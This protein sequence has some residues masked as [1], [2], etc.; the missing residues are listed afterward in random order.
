MKR[1]A[2]IAVAMLLAVL[3]LA[4]AAPAATGDDFPC[5]LGKTT[6]ALFFPSC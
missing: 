4:P 5:V 6:L 1:F 3:T 2:G